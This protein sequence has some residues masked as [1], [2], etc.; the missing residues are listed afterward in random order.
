VLGIFLPIL[1]T[2]P[3]L[4]LTAACYARGSVRFYNWLLN[5]RLF[6]PFIRDWRVHKSLPLRTKVIILAVLWVTIITTSM[7]FIPVRIGQIAIYIVPIGVT[8]LMVRIPTRR[9]A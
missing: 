1:P 6:G 3:L 8:Y 7:F 2:T 4:L 9:T 5:N